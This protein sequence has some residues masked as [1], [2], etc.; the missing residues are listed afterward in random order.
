LILPVSIAPAPSGTLYCTAKI[1]AMGS[2]GRSSGYAETS[3]A[4]W[5]NGSTSDFVGGVAPTITFT[6]SGPFTG[7]ATW[8]VATTPNNLQLYV[9]S[10][11][12]V[13]FIVTFEWFQVYTTNM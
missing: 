5:Y 7:N 6:T 3:A 10:T 13:N 8:D 11:D 1:V 9:R 4:I 2:D 12:S